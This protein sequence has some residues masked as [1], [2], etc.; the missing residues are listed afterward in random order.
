MTDRLRP[1][2]TRPHAFANSA[3]AQNRL[4]PTSEATILPCL[5]VTRCSATPPLPAQLSPRAEI[6][7]SR[8]VTSL[9]L[10][11]VEMS[12]RHALSSRMPSPRRFPPPWSIEESDACFTADRPARSKSP[13]RT[14]QRRGLFREHADPPI[15]PFG[16]GRLS[17]SKLGHG[18]SCTQ[19]HYRS[20]R[21]RIHGDAHCLLPSTKLSDA[22]AVAARRSA[23]G[24]GLPRVLHPSSG[25]LT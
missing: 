24:C 5:N 17:K 3:F 7:I 22:L 2:H 8:G 10:R 15:G 16:A 13:L 12:R 23:T 9:P 14:P 1:V 11:H 25:S 20:P 19:L 6:V 21:E 18:R 4:T